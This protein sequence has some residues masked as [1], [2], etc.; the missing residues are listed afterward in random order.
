M[1]HESK[2][3]FRSVL[4]SSHYFV[5]RLARFARS[6]IRPG[7]PNGGGDR[8]SIAFADPI[9]QGF[10]QVGVALLDKS[11]PVY[12]ESCTERSEVHF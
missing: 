6:P 1:K 2:S 3:G 5:T 11:V 10:V 7:G 12:A 9:T 8:G 4:V